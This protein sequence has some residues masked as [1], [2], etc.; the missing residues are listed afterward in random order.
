M[1]YLSI[2]LVWIK[3]ENSI[4]E[5]LENAVCHLYNKAKC[6]M[7]ICQN[8]T[9]YIIVALEENN[10]DQTDKRDLSFG[11]RPCLTRH[12]T[13]DKLHHLSN[14]QF[15]QYKVRTKCPYFIRL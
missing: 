7:S 12:M 9:F 14:L 8:Y 15:P 4:R 10:R 5:A 1:A 6:F 2:T 3:N 13:Q 11:L